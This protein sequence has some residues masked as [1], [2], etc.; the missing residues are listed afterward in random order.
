MRLIR[1]H[2]DDNPTLLPAKAIKMQPQDNYSVQ[3]RLLKMLT[4]TICVTT[5]ADDCGFGCFW[6]GNGTSWIQ[7]AGASSGGAKSGSASLPAAYYDE[8]GPLSQSESAHDHLCHE[9]DYTNDL[10]IFIEKRTI[11]NFD[12]IPVPVYKIKILEPWGME[13]NY[14]LKFCLR[15]KFSQAQLRTTTIICLRR[16]AKSLSQSL[17]LSLFSAV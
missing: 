7:S 12:T 6:T 15:G 3:H 17:S 16:K 4:L 5:M 9:D 8:G 11:C 13:A 1:S 14:Q 10:P 2:N